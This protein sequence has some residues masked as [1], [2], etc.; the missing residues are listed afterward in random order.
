VPINV[1]L[2]IQLH[3]QYD[4]PMAMIYV[5]LLTCSLYI[6]SPTTY[7]SKYRV[8]VHDTVLQEIGKSLDA[9]LQ[10]V[11]ITLHDQVSTMFMDLLAISLKNS[12]HS[13]K[14]GA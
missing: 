5:Q 14:I 8:H 13:V 3:V 9:M 4:N 12:N 2:C 1:H 6:P 7:C 10:N 11:F